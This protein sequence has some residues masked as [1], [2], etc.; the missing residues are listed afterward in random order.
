L[1]KVTIYHNP[2]CRKSR[3]ALQL[4]RDR[5]HDVEVIE[6]L[7]D[8]PSA[9]RLAELCRGLQL[10][11]LQLMRVKEKKFAELGL[12]RGD[13]RS[14]AQWCKIMSENPILIER[15]IVVAGKRVALGRPVEAI[16]EI[17]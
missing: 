5:G 13:R 10:Q 2:R 15:P 4:L 12:S 7:K 9:A 3:E 6:Y 11:P 1:A 14:S 16:L 8:P 17:L